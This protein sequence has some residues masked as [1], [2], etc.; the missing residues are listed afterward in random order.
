[1][2]KKRQAR[3]S[4]KFKKAVAS[5]RARMPKQQGG[6]VDER[7]MEMT[8]RGGPGSRRTQAPTPAE[9]PSS[10]TAVAPKFQASSTEPNII[11]S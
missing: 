11:W 2:S 6:A 3:N 4:R 8:T 1:M 5:K 7:E 9:Q 10:P